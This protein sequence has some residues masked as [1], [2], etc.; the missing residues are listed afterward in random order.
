MQ[1]E[2]QEKSA[3]RETI[4]SEDDI[5]SEKS[6]KEENGSA[7][8]LKI[9]KSKRAL[10]YSL[11]MWG[12]QGF[13]IAHSQAVR[14]KTELKIFLHEVMYLANILETGSKA[15]LKIQKTIPASSSMPKTQEQLYFHLTELNRSQGNWNRVLGQSLKLIGGAIKVMK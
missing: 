7:L 8:V 5:Q 10:K 12:A 14:S 4:A 13:Q 15:S 2:N 3:G 9:L 1:S 6:E 11:D